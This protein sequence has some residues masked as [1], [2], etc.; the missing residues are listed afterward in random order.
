MFLRVPLSDF[1]MTE[2]GFVSVLRRRPEK[3]EDLNSDSDTVVEPSCENATNASIQGQSI[4]IGSIHTLD[5]LREVRPFAIED[6]IFQRTTPDGE[7]VYGKFTSQSF[8]PVLKCHEQS[9]ERFNKNRSAPS[10]N[11]KSCI[12]QDPSKEPF[13]VH[14]SHT[15]DCVSWRDNNI[16]SCNETIFVGCMYVGK[17]G[18]PLLK[19]YPSK[20]IGKASML[21]VQF[22]S[23]LNGNL[24]MVTEE[25]LTEPPGADKIRNFHHIKATQADHICPYSDFRIEYVPFNF[26][27]I[28]ILLLYHLL[29]CVFQR[30]QL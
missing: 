16:E 22:N 14:D 8:Y 26:A 20:E 11:E 25:K 2:Q 9:V 3:H 10:V 5:G 23:L 7:I 27:E 28:G 12:I 18:R 30:F 24:Q 6:H 4:L 1:L 13:C 21:N 19:D 29:K 15:S 17:N